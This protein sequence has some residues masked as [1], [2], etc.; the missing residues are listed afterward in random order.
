MGHRDRIT[1]V[2]TK[3]PA[4]HKISGCLAGFVMQ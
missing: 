3:E 1:Y 4:K 2:I